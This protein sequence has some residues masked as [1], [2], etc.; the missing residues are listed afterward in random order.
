MYQ[1]HGWFFADQ[2]THF[3]HMIE[4]NIKKGG[5]A[6][7]QEPV[8]KKSLEFVSDYGVAVDIGA[9]VGLWSRDLAIKFARVIA[10]EP[11]VEFQECL[12]RNVPMENIEVWPFALGTEDTTIDMIITE[13]NTGHSHINKDSV[14]SG[15]VEMKRL[16]SLDF[17]RIDYM[18]IDCEGYEMQ[19]LK[20]GENT[21]RTHQPIIVVEQ[22]LH[23]DT[24]ITKETQYG[25]VDLLKS[26]G[27]R[28]LGRVRNDC[29]LGW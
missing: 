29:I 27:A 13:G 9:N 8:R 21:L 3:S 7:Y 24:G 2:D 16:D 19:I 26:W 18:K 1:A 20:G 12:R 5:P 25:C 14:G 28:E 17:D 10:I 15:K 4:K 23:T 22:K 6:A 11:V